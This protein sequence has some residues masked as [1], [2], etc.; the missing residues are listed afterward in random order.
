MDITRSILTVKG[1]GDYTV[2]ER[3]AWSVVACPS[4]RNPNM[5]VVARQEH[6]E[7]QPPGY[8]LNAWLLCV[9]CG[10][11]TVG[12]RFGRVSPAAMEFPTPDGTPEAET[13]LWQEVRACLSID[14]YNAVAMLCRKLLLHLVFTHERSQNPQ[15]TPRRMT[16]AQAVQHLL[17]NAVIIAS[18]EPLAKEIKDIG[19]K[20]NHELPDITQEE[21]RKIALFT[22]FLFTSVYEMPKRSKHPNRFRWSRR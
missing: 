9:G 5:L 10:Q 6:D 7:F 11:A 21:A 19:N 12:D 4:C 20:A 16:F 13:N 18:Y 8:A 15:A 22:Y 17:D 1:Y 2:T 3:E 14:A